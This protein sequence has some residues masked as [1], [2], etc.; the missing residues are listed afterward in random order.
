MNTSQLSCCTVTALLLQSVVSENSMDTQL[1]QNADEKKLNDNGKIWESFL[2]Y[3]EDA[4]IWESFAA[5]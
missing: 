4:E 3:N 5:L 1:M 2:C